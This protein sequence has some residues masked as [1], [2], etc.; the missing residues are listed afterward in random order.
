[1]EVK[2]ESNC[3]GEEPLIAELAYVIAKLHCDM[4]TP[5]DGGVPLVHEVIFSITNE[6]GE[7]IEKVG[8]Q[9]FYFFNTFAELIC[10]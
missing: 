1:V 3:V 2:S 10:L 6:K 9:Q 5:D 7:P 4:Y 8:C